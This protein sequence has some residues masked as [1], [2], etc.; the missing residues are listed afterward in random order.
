MIWVFYSIWSLN[1]GKVNRKVFL[2]CGCIMMREGFSPVCDN[3][4]ICVVPVYNIGRHCGMLVMSSWSWVMAEYVRFTPAKWGVSVCVC[5]YIYNVYVCVC[6]YLL[7]PPGWFVCVHA[8]AF[9]CLY[10]FCVCVY[11]C[12]YICVCVCVC[13]YVCIYVCVCVCVYLLWPPGVVRLC[14]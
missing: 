6:V 8:C 9:I 14:T 13:V 7:W 2:L 4:F 12:I 1:S 10:W 11:V 5:V 3:I